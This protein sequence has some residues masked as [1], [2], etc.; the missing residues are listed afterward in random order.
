MCCRISDASEKVPSTSM[1]FMLLIAIVSHMDTQTSSRK[2]AAGWLVKQC[3]SSESHTDNCAPG[4]VSC[5]T[6]W[7]SGY[8]SLNLT[9]PNWT[10]HMI[11]DVVTHLLAQRPEAT[12]PWI[13]NRIT[14]TVWLA[15]RSSKAGD[16][17]VSGRWFVDFPGLTC[18]GWAK[19]FVNYYYFRRFANTAISSSPHN[20]SVVVPTLFV[21][22]SL[23][24]DRV[25]TSR[26]RWDNRA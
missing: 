17:S 10:R 24:W 20:R 8:I 13:W 19:R 5:T 15:L 25:A 18:F 6:K 2:A 3:P 22:I 21:L 23:S 12:I 11:V 9:A 7:M 14:R 16:S 26:P 4:F 1:T